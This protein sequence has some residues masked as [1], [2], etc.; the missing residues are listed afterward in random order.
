MVKKLNAK[1]FKDHQE[2]GS[3]KVTV[4]MNIG[5]KWMISEL[6]YLERRSQKKVLESMLQ[7]YW[8]NVASKME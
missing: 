1:N 2:C 6:A 8:D 4:Y 3:A 5:H 7:Y